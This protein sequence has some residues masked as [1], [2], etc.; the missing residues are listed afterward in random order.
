MFD[1]YVSAS[2]SSY[3]QT[4]LRDAAFNLGVNLE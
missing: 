2:Y 4:Y 3:I 1:C